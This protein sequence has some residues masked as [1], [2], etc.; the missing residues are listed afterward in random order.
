MKTKLKIACL[1]L[2]LGLVACSEATHTT[3]GSSAAVDVNL[4]NLHQDIKVLASDE[5]SGRGPLTEGEA[6]TVNFLTQQYQNMGLVGAVNGEFIQ[7]VEMAQITADQNMILNI[8]ELNFRAGSD[9]T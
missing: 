2:S 8:G 4:N 1:V 6:L 9:F 7:A 5:F 3:T